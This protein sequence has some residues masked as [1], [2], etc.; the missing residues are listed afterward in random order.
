MKQK[1]EAPGSWG[2]KSQ[3]REKMKQKAAAVASGSFLPM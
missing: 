3:T 1:K 2:V